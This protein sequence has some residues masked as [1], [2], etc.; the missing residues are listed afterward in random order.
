MG[1]I[2]SLLGH[3]PFWRL[4]HLAGGEP[5]QIQFPLGQ[6]SIQTTERYLGYNQRIR[7]AVNDKNW[8]RAA[9]LSGPAALSD[10]PTAHPGSSNPLKRH[11]LDA[12]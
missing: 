11:L 2:L 12:I 8:D 4:C 6:V 10:L 3:T 9:R 7:G 1:S 5:E